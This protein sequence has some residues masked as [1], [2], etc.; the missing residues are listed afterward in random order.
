MAS[1]IRFSEDTEGVTDPK[2]F[3]AAAVSADVR[4]KQDGRLGC[5][6]RVFANALRGGWSIHQ[7]CS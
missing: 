3:F 2:G 7:E 5:R 6:H 4:N 1:D